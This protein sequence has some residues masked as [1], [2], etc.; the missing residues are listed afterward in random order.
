MSA[1][2]NMTVLYCSDHFLVVD[3]PYDMVI[4]SNDPQVKVIIIKCCFLNNFYKKTKTKKMIK[5]IQL[6]YHIIKQ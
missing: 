5:K 6:N 2:N 3:K 1:D 4:N